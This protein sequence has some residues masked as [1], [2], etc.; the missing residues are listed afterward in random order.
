MPAFLA[1]VTTFIVVW[2]AEYSVVPGVLVKIIRAD[3]LHD[4]SVRKSKNTWLPGAKRSKNTKYL[5]TWSE[6]VGKKERI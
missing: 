3:L 4:K 6:N 5:V 1:L 2:L